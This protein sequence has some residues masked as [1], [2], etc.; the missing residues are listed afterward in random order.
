MKYHTAITVYF[1][2]IKT[3]IPYKKSILLIPLIT[4]YVIGI[5]VYIIAYCVTFNMIL[6]TVIFIYYCL[7]TFILELKVI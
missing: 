4:F 3:S 7:L 5:T 1:K 6:V 2:L